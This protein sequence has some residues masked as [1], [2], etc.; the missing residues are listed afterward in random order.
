MK[1]S[2]KLQKIY[3]IISPFFFLFF[4]ILAFVPIVIVRQTNGLRKSKE[5]ILKLLEVVP[6]KSP[7]LLDKDLG[8]LKDFLYELNKKIVFIPDYGHDYFI[9]GY[10][11]APKEI[12]PFTQ[13]MNLDDCI[14]VLFKNS[15]EIS[16]LSYLHTRKIKESKYFEVREI[17]HK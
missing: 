17:D 13:G 7:N 4:L 1:G 5:N 2:V 8:Q 16:K 14:I 15:S 11:L 9:L 3:S 12:F 6:Y 10:Y